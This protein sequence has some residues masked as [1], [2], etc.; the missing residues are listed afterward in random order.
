MERFTGQ[1]ETEQPEIERSS[2]Y[3]FH[4]HGETYYLHPNNTGII[5]VE[6][7]PEYSYVLQVN[8]E[9]KQLIN[10]PIFNEYL[11][12]WLMGEIAD[13]HKLTIERYLGWKLEEPHNVSVQKVPDN[14][15]RRL[16]HE[17]DT[18]DLRSSIGI[19]RLV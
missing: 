17:H 14:H 8:Q 11:I 16:K 18:W 15:D 3:E 10:P 1:V 19:E 13:K 2:C 5:L 7:E 4:Y 6:S 12:A 9:T